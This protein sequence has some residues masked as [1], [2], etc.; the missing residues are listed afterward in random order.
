MV[1]VLNIFTII[2]SFIFIV[3]CAIFIKTVSDARLEVLLDK[4]TYDPNST[5][6]YAD[7]L[8]DSVK[9]TKNAGITCMLFLLFYA[10]VGVITLIKLKTKTMKIISI[11]GISFTAIMLIWDLLV[12]SSSGAITFDEVGRTYILFG[13]MQLS[14]SIVG[15]V[16]AFRKKV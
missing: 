10:M 14:F 13:L 16:H 15:T 6:R 2:A 11:I 12:I 3:I 5:P 9:L 4:L 7:S 8:G 1:R